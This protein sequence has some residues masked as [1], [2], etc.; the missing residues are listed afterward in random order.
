[1][2]VASPHVS[3]SDKTVGTTL[4]YGTENDSTNAGLGVVNGTPVGDFRP[5]VPCRMEDGVPFPQQI[6]LARL[7]DLPYSMVAILRR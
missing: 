5:S 6:R 2:L 7:F 4:V 3:S 1:M